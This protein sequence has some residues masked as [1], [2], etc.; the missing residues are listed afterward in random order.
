[1]VLGFQTR[2]PRRTLVQHKQPLGCDLA[3]VNLK[4]DLGCFAS[5][6]FEYINISGK[7]GCFASKYFEYINISGK[8][9][10][11]TDLF[12]CQT[13]LLGY[14]SFNLSP[15]HAKNHSSFIPSPHGI[16]FYYFIV[17]YWDVMF[18]N[19]KEQFPKH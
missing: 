16:S 18:D 12:I 2:W 7:L 14:F 13:M 5:K 3:R 17:P 9:L 4:K 19:F 11:H 8:L 1:M 15:K 10:V 6:Y